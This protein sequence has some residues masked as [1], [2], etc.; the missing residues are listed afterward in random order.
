MFFQSPNNSDNFFIMNATQ[1]YVVNLT[2]SVN[3][4]RIWCEVIEL[5]CKHYYFIIFCMHTLYTACFFFY[6]SRFYSS[7]RKSLSIAS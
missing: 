2:M 6:P 3:F 4:L 5:N 1:L 7:R